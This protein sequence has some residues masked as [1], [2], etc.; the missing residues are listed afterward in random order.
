MLK[1][2]SGWNKDSHKKV[3]ILKKSKTRMKERIDLGK[4]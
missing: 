2:N 3:K 1:T 4:M